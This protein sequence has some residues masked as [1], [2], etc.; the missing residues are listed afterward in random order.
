M[1]WAE[2]HHVTIR[3]MFTVSIDERVADKTYCRLSVQTLLFW[4]PKTSARINSD[5][6]EARTISSLI[7]SCS[8]SA[9][10]GSCVY[11]EKGGEKNIAKCSFDRCKKL[12]AQD[13]SRDFVLVRQIKLLLREQPAICSNLFSSNGL[14]ICEA[15]NREWSKPGCYTWLGYII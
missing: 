2:T 12:W 3:P 5:T 10:I 14:L 6:I 1:F 8:P 13:V 7:H 11:Y 4:N 9:L 15:I